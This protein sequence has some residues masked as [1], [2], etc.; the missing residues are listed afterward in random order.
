MDAPNAATALSAPPLAQVRRGRLVRERTVLDR[1]GLKTGDMYRVAYVAGGVQS[2]RVSRSLVVFEGITERRRWDGGA[3]SCLD[4]V[5]PQG[6][7]LSLL[8]SQI[9]DVRPAG[10]NERGQWVLLAEGRLR[11]RRRSARRSL[12]G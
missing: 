8:A 5:L 11:R 3:A 6:R 4:F 10:L 2:R 7:P 12:S 9:V 1:F